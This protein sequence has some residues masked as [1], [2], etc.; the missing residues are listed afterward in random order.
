[1]NPKYKG[2]NWLKIKNMVSNDISSVVTIYRYKN[3]QYI[4]LYFSVTKKIQKVKRK[5]K[6]GHL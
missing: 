2:K 4:S 3:M 6:I 5:S 1:M